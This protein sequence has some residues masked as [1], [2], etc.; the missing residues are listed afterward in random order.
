VAVFPQ[1]SAGLSS[2]YARS[3]ALVQGSLY[4]AF[5]LSIAEAMLAGKP[6]IAFRLASI[7]DLV[8]DEVTGCL[9]KPVCSMDLATKTLD[10]IGNE[11][12][13]RN[14]GFHAKKTVGDLYNFQVVGS[15]MENVLKEV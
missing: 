3:A 5:S 13:T 6:I 14:M 10:L 1:V 9:A 12:K 15:R 2:L 11:E 7:P 8:T 4:E